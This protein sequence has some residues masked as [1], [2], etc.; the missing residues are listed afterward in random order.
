[1][2]KTSDICL[3][4]GMV[5]TVTE[6]K[7]AFDLQVRQHPNIV[8]VAK[9]SEEKNNWMYALISLLTWR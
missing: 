4:C 6:L 7:N 9:S 1:M 2:L 5:F 3:I 8:L